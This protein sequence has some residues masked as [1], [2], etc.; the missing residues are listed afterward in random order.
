MKIGLIDVDS[1]K[2]PNIALMKISAY[3]K[4]RLDDVSFYKGNKKYDI[5]Y[6]SKIFTF[7]KEKYDRIKAEQVIKGGSGYDLETKLPE[8]IDNL[9]PDYSLY[10]IT[11]TAYGYLTRGCFRK[12]PFCIVSKKEGNETKQV[13][14]LNQ[15]WNG[16]KN[17]VLLDPNITAARN[18][19]D[20]FNEL[21]ETRAYVDFTQGLDLRLLTEA[22]VD[23]LR[24]IRVKRVHFAW[25]NIKD[26]KIII[27]K[28][29][30]LKSKTNWT[31]SKVTAYVLVNYNSTFEEDLYRVNTLKDMDVDPYIMIYNAKTAEQKYKDLRSY[32]NA[33]PI[34]RT[35]KSFEEYKIK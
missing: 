10:N 17:I 3:H 28:L 25:D 30:M 21:A 12:C 19:L 4:E 15:F 26:E 14:K 35:V 13:Y 27:E 34:F 18:K 29:K 2:F 24:K 9:Y 23:A 32:V 22:D 31:R 7:S 20:L 16:Q 33:R 6:M 1:R 5:A 8:E 11:D